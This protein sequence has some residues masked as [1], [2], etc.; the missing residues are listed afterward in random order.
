MAAIK[1]SVPTLLG[2]VSQQPDP[3]KLPGQV[4]EAENVYL[5]PTFGCVKRPPTKLISDL[6]NDIPD[7]AEWFSIFRDDNERYL[8]CV[9]LAETAGNG[10]AANDRIFRVFE[11]DSGTERTVT[12][13]TDVQ[14]Y[15]RKGG[16]NSYKNLK[17][18][19][20]GDYT[21][22]CNP[23]STVTMSKGKTPG[24]VE[25]AFVV[26]NQIGYNTDYR[27]DILKEDETLTQVKEFSATEI[28]VSP[29]SFEKE[30]G[31]GGCSL[32]GFKEVTTSNGLKYRLTVN[33]TPVQVT[34][35]QAGEPFPT[36]VE[37]TGTSQKRFA[38]WAAIKL[39]SPMGLALGSYGYAVVNGTMKGKAIGIRVEARVQ[40]I[41]KVNSEKNR[42][43]WV[44]SSLDVV[45]YQSGG[46]GKNKWKTGL[47]ESFKVTSTSWIKPGYAK[48]GFDECKD[49]SKELPPGTSRTIRVKL[50]AIDK[51][52]KT[53]VYS[54]KS[55][56]QASVQLLNGGGGANGPQKG[57]VFTTTLNGKTYKIK[58]KKH[59]TTKAFAADQSF[60]HTTPTDATSGDLDVAS[61]TGALTSQINAVS[62]YTAENIGNV[63]RITHNNNK[64][65]NISARGGSTDN[66]MYAIK[67]T[68]NDVSR[69]PNQGWD[70]SILKVQN[71]VDTEADD[72]YVKFITGDGIPGAGSWEECAQPD[73]KTSLNADTMPHALKRKKNGS[74][75]IIN[76]EGVDDEDPVQWADREVGDDNT[77]P[78]PTFV[79]K[80]INNMVFHMNRFGFLSEDTVILSQPGDYFNFFVGSAISVSDADP[81]DMAATSTRPANLIN[82][83]STTQGLL[84]FS[85]D[86]QFLMGTRDVAFGPS[87]V[88]VNE[89][90]NYAFRSTVAPIEVGTSIFFSSD[91]T[92][93][94]KV[95]EMA[96]DSIGDNPQ[97]AED[98]RIVPEYLP[99]EL[100]WSAASSNNNLALF[101][102]KSNDVYAF[103]YYN[104]GKERSLAGWFKWVFDF[105]VQ[106]IEFYDDVAYLVL[107]NDE[108]DHT[109][110]ATM[111]LMDDP[112]S[113]TITAD[114]RK[115]EPRLDVYARKADLTVTP[116]AD[117]T[118][119]NLPAGTFVGQE[120]AYL[121]FNKAA[122][123]YFTAE[124]IQFD[125]DALQT[126][127]HI[128]VSNFTLKGVNDYNLGLAYNMRVRLPSFY[129]K[130]ES[131][132]D[133]VDIPMI[134]NVNVELYLSGSYDVTLERL[135]Y[136]DRTLYFTSKVADVYK[137]DRNPITD[138]STQKVA[139][140]CRGDH[141]SLTIESLDPLPVGVTGYTWE[142]HYNNRGISSV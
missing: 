87:T 139:V 114:E 69:L 72:Y 117:T 48:A 128:I 25:E 12:Y 41:C 99:N 124:D 88:Q 93:F 111:N 101:G 33:C 8:G 49:D 121:Q 73:L 115:F 91:S 45:S 4:R 2:G 55:S 77:N 50:T 79:G 108:T 63:I 40:K 126:N 118:R 102:N 59:V 42:V 56:Y 82:G 134:E 98:T 67:N 83:I 47:K 112:D 60:N 142:G 53:P 27:V 3:I 123:T 109:L 113:A 104:Q 11:A 107:Y 29:G 135:G 66:A 65:F 6:D 76:L 95:F 62:H 110:I 70:G 15:L 16:V 122:G 39:G 89:I 38:D 78:I 44:L 119:I 80:K 81:I 133:R 106:F 32:A 116:G 24:E 127:P 86:A 137:L 46:T 138:T 31:T 21:F 9:Y 74:F 37:L 34:D 103:K 7:N 84:L 1:Q 96:I 125:D 92:T 75:E 97:V 14:E 68:V 51:G 130:S 105:S 141:A 71:T 36:Q 94:S 26:I 20:I 52:P 35:Y 129:A 28:N 100:E 30:D 54:F 132:V 43:K 131:K 17:F 5:D 85:T 120:Q 13:G 10:F 140:F 90:S 136:E 64:S 57:D 22:I 18:K 61:V 58:V 23:S 19:T